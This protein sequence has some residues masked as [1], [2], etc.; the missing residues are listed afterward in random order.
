MYNLFLDTTQNY[1]HIAIFTTSKIVKSVSVKT[2]NN[3]T[4]LVVEHINKILKNANIRDS[5]IS[6]LYLL[7][8]PGSFT[9][10]R[11]GCLIAKTWAMIKNIKIYALDS[12]RFQ[13]SEPSG[14]SIL[15]ARGN[16]KYVC[17]IKNNKTIIKPKIT[18][19][20]ELA[21]IINKYND[22]HVFKQF[23]NANVFDNLL[24]NLSLFKEIKDIKKM[25]PN[26]IKKPI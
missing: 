4:D 11:V 6:S 8:G 17:V 18:N 15:D 7:I 9:G 13:I 24:K 5:H 10:L 25:L 22:L 16:N 26:Y 2:N 19:T 20:K 1:C 3:L 23:E 21:K 12:L 14:I